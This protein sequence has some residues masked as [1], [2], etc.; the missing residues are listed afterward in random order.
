M[1]LE[2]RDKESSPER[3]GAVDVV[4][5]MSADR[6]LLGWVATVL[7]AAL[8]AAGATVFVLAGL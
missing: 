6:R 4:P 7:G 8:M 1:M 2:T 5:S 3:N